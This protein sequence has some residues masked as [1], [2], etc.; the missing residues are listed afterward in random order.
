[1]GC[2][3]RKGSG[4][5]FGFDSKFISLVRIRVEFFWIIYGY[6]FDF[7]C[8]GFLFFGFRLFRD[9]R[10]YRFFNILRRRV[11]WWWGIIVWYLGLG[12]CFWFFV[13]LSS[14]CC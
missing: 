13:I 5:I 4:F 10:E 11:I 14:R 6:Y 9:F 7:G 3:F 8:I 12:S 2:F 1:M